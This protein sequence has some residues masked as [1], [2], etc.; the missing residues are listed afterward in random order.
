MTNKTPKATTTPGNPALKKQVNQG[1]K[2]GRYVLN[3]KRVAV[4]VQTE[5]PA[6]PEK[7][8]K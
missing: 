3:E 6:T 8:E 7:E 5:T 2:G 4:L 1:M